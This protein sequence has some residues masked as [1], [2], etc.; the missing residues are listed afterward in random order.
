VAITED[1]RTVRHSGGFV[2]LVIDKFELSGESGMRSGALL[3]FFKTGHM[4]I[5]VAKLFEVDPV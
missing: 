4:N 2:E 1:G 3:G 5:G